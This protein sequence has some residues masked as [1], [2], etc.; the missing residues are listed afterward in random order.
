MVNYEWGNPA[1]ITD[2]VEDIKKKIDS[3][4]IRKVQLCVYV[5]PTDGKTNEQLQL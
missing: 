1:V 3:G 5:E 2:S 4:D